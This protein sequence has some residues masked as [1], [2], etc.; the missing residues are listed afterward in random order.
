M[1]EKWL[2]VE[3][4]AKTTEAQDITSLLLADVDG[5]AL[6]AF[7][8]GAHIDLETPSGLV[9]QYSLCNAPS[10]AGRYRIGVLRDPASR[11]GSRSVHD[12]VA[13][14]TRLRISEPKNHF[15]LVDGDMSVL[16]AGGIGVTPILAM[17]ESL[18]QGQ[19]P[20]EFHYC[21]RTAGRTAFVGRIQASPFAGQVHFHFDD[22]PAG[23]RFDIAAALAAPC[24]GKHLYVCGP[25]GFM[26]AV[27]E[28]AKTMGWRQECIHF[29]YF[30]GAAPSTSGNDFDIVVA[31]SGR[32]IRV[33]EGVTVVEALRQHGVDVPV[34]CEQGV[35]G[36]C[37]TRVIDG[38]PDHRDFYMTDAEHARN[39]Q[40]TP[41]CSRSR[42]PRLVLDL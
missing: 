15:P 27:I 39:D 42:S 25:K 17:A 18:A 38:I 13:A 20:F 30:A 23:Q 33:Q 2:Q 41:C 3:V 14:G 32:V 4:V 26:D 12:D 10:E 24:D 9:R 16:I 36:T 5:D 28:G 6:P 8:A 1:N 7:T 35:C 34:S 22:G 37:V 21:S 29:E 31:S 11:G 19:K 40:F